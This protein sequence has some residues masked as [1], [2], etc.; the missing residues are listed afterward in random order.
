MNE[1]EILFSEI[2]NCDRL[3]LYLDKDLF[4][5]KD[6][7]S[8]ISSVLKRRIYGEPIQYILGKTEFM[9]FEFKLTKNVLI[10]RPETEIVVET[11]I[12]YSY[13]VPS[14]P[15]TVN[16]L[17][18]GTGSG[19]IAVSLAK[20]LNNVKI[21]A[22]DISAEALEVARY[23]ASWNNVIDKIKFIKSDLFTNYEAINNKYEI[24]VSN[25]P[26]IKSGEIENL[27]PELAY[28]P[29]IAL[30]GGGDGLDFYRKIIGP[31]AHYLVGG[32]F[33]ILEIGYGQK[34]AL[35]GIFQKSLGF[36]IIEVVGDY[37]NIN[38]AIV[39]RKRI[40]NDGQVDY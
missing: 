18:I 20:N 6:K 35:E 14:A 32:G 28:E 23:N 24:I 8:R 11:A 30:D 39:A 29:R 10:P 2:F 19:C 36:E 34:E 33:L 40:G 4:V 9:G 27:A 3:S 22:I 16:I 26:Y 21:T 1:A 17:D 12:K 38:R 5:N 7:A 25:P 31:A 15:C 37:N 13:N